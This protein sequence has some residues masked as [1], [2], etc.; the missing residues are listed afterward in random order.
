MPARVLSSIG[1]VNLRFD[2]TAA[3]ADQEK[4][5]LREKPLLS[6]HTQELLEML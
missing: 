2:S 6:L 1:S 5:Q 4:E 3:W